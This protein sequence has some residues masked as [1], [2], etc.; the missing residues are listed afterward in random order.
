MNLSINQS[1]CNDI[2]CQRK[3]SPNFK[4]AV[5]ID[6]NAM[7]I[8]KNQT[9]K[10]NNKA[11][12]GNVCN[13]AYGR[14]WTKLNNTISRQQENPVNIIIRKNKMRNGLTAE[15]V[16]SEALSA[17][18]NQKHSQPLFCKNGDLNFL[19]KAEKTADKINETNIRLGELTKAVKKDYRAGSR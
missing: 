11:K 8:I 1:N 4:M 9:L 18:K 10:L 14:F 19:D 7:K 15:V 3:N 13:T 6:S 12:D 17:V 5:K 2:S 16:D